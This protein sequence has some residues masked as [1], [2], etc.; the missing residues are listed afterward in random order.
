MRRSTAWIVDPAVHRGYIT[1]SK[2]GIP[3]LAC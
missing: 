2:A 3:V 1:G